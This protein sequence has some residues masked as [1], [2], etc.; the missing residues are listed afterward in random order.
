MF[1]IPIF[2]CIDLAMQQL[3][4]ILQVLFYIPNE[5]LVLAM[6][7]P[8]DQMIIFVHCWYCSDRTML[9]KNATTIDKNAEAER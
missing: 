2:H 3:A 8:S 6:T 1:L 5:K 4:C 7:V 9:D